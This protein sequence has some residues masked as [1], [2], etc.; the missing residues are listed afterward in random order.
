MLLKSNLVS[1]TR[2]SPSEKRIEGDRENTIDINEVV[3]MVADI[4]A[5]TVILKFL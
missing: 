3:Y 2:I 4:D 5:I 1:N